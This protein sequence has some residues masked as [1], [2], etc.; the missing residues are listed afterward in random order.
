MLDPSEWLEAA[1]ALPIGGKTSIAHGCGSGKKLLIENKEAGWVAWCYRCS[2]KGFVPKPK[3]SLSE[4]IARL[5]E[6]RKVD[7]A[8]AATITP[9]KPIVLDMAEWPK[10]ATSWLGGVGIDQWWAEHLG[11]YWNP[12]LERVVMP[13][14]DGQKLCFWQARSFDPKRPKYLSPALAPG[15]P[16]PV[17]K[18]IPFRGEPDRSRLVL[19]EDI[20]SAI[21]V[22]EVASAWSILGTS[23]TALRSAEIANYGASEVLVWLDPDEAGI[24]GRRRIVPELRSLGVNARAIRGA[25]KDPK[26]YNQDEIRSIIN[27]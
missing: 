6:Q 25:T 8:A 20:L 15:Q 19:T 4:R 10:A 23:L 11:F 9:P 16:K 26:L 13:V 5:R 27:G 3:P 21:K 7:Q 14:L 24:K 12:R 2:D 22:G 1:K 17:Y 18:A